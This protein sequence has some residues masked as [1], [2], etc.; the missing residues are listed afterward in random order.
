VDITLEINLAGL[1]LKNP[2][3]LASGIMGSS[4]SLLKRIAKSGIGAVVTKTLTAEPRKGYDPP[5]IYSTRCYTL[6]AVGLANPGIKNF[7]NDIQ[8]AKE[9]NIPVIVSLAGNSPE[10]FSWMA[11]LAQDYGADGVELNLSCPH[12]KGLGTELGDDPVMVENVVRSVKKSVKI[13]VFSKLTPNTSDI[14]I[15]GFSSVKGGADGLVAVNT[16]RGMVIDVELKAP[17]LSNIYG[18][19]SGRALHPIA[20]YSV[21]RL[22]SNINVPII[23]V[24]GIETWRDI[25]EFILA[26]ATA[27]QIGTVLISN[28]PEIIV[29]KLIKGITNYMKRH[30][31]TNI[32]SMRGII[33][34]K[35][36]FEN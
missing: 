33:H 22:S 4:G 21:Y 7:K 36:Y 29:P 13:P 32:E 3:M 11:G 25:I 19:V 5:I 26:G 30:N 6:N 20:V 24:G 18:G 8:E 28:D 9:C 23:G 35:K 31:F 2:I 15:Q 17:V 34:K 10:E 14:L 16:L 1:R 12:V 27:V